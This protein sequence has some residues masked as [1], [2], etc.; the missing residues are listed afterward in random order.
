MN[1]STNISMSNKDSA[2]IKE[3]EQESEQI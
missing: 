3:V 1:D 2:D